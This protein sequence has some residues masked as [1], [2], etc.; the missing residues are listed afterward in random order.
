MQHKNTKCN[1]NKKTPFVCASGMVRHDKHSF[2]FVIVKRIFRRKMYSYIMV[3]T[4][5]FPTTLCIECSSVSSQAPNTS[6]HRSNTIDFFCSFFISFFGTMAAASIENREK[7]QHDEVNSFF[8]FE[9]GT[10]GAESVCKLCRKNIKGQLHYN[11]SRHLTLVHKIAVTP[12]INKS[13]PKE[14]S[15]KLVKVSMRIDL[16]KIRKGYVELVTINGRPYSAVEDNG[17]K[18]ITEPI[19]DALEKAGLPFTMN[20]TK[21]LDEIGAYAL[22]VQNYI[23]MEVKSKPISVM[24]DIATRYNLSVLGV[25]VQFVVDGVVQVRHLGMVKL[26]TSHSGAYICSKLLEILDEFDIEKKFVFS[27]TN[28]NGTNVIKS[29]EILEFIKNEIDVALI[30][31]AMENASLN[32]ND[33]DDDFEW[34]NDCN[35]DQMALNQYDTVMKEAAEQLGVTI[36]ENR[37]FLTENLLRILLCGSHTLE[38]AIKDA[39]NGSPIELKLLSDCREMM[40]L[41]RTPKYVNMLNLWIQN[42]PD[43]AEKLLRPVIDN[44]TRWGSKFKMVKNILKIF[45]I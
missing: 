34:T 41:L 20:R 18:K 8:D 11:N 1:N 26:E 17:L 19:V 10:K 13:A 42:H 5:V 14:Q 12:K 37:A 3:A 40:K 16:E 2:A 45:L 33:F 22:K 6:H 28:D 44:E 24:L 4:C 38:L 29:A 31:K 27:V 35:N 7:I 23:K 43:V 9:T 15:E 32:E 36:S 25:S 21:I 30:Q 39:V